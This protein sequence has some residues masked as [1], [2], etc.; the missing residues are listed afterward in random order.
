MVVVLVVPP[1]LFLSPL[2]V[3]RAFLDGDNFLQNFPLRVL[4]GEDIRQGSLPLLNPYLFSGTPLLGGFNAGAAYPATW[5][6]A[7]LPRFVAWSL[8][9]AVAYDV[10][11][12]GTFAYLRRQSLGVTPATFAAATFAFAGYMSGQIVHVDLIQ[13]AAWLPWAL[14]AVDALLPAAP[15]DVRAPVDRAR[16]ARWAAVLALVVGLTVLTGGAEVIIDGLLAVALY[17]LWQLV[18]QW[19]RGIGSRAVVVSAAW[20]L[21]G[22]AGGI[23]LGSAQWLPGLVFQSRSQRAIG[24]YT[25]FTT[26]SLDYHL[27][28]LLVSPFVLGTNQGRPTLF[29]G[30]YNLPEATGYAGVL[31]LIAVAVLWSRRFRRRPE[32]RA[33]RVW[34]GLGAVFLLS[35]LGG[36]TPFGHV[37]YLLPL[38]RDERLLNRNLLVVDFA[39]AVLLGWWLQ[40]L[41]DRRAD[42]E[43]APARPR[44]GSTRWTERIGWAPGR[45]CEILLTVTPAAL[46]VVAA[47][48]WWADGPLVLRLLDA[49][50]VIPASSRRELAALVTLGALIGVAGTAL[51]LIER[52]L[53]LVA[54]R[55]GLATVLA[56]DLVVLTVFLLHT[57][58][59]E[60]TAQAQTPQAAALARQAAGGRFLVYD[61]DQFFRDDLYAVGQTDLNVFAGTASGQGYTALT[62][63]HYYAATGAHFQEDLDPASLRGPLWDGL[64]ARVLLSLPGYFVTPSGP[65]PAGGSSVP[66]PP[67]PSPTAR[68]FTGAP[69]PADAPVT[70]APGRSHVWYLGGTLSVSQWSVPVET[71]SPDA[72]RAGVIAADGT[73]VAAPSTAVGHALEASASGAPLAGVVVRNGSP[74]TVVVGVPTARTAQAG[75]VALEG[76]MQYGVDASHWRF[77]G[78]LGPFGLFANTRAR[79]WAWAAA[80]PGGTSARATVAAG[81]PAVDGSQDVR[82]RSAGR[83][84]LVRSMAWTTGWR[85]T[86]DPVPGGPGAGG[87]SRLLQVRRDGVLQRVTVPPGDWT[88][89]FSYQPASATLGL[90][91]SLLA[92]VA[93]AGFL[94]V[95]GAARLRSGRRRD[96]DGDRGPIPGEPGAQPGGSS[97]MA[98]AARL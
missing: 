45:R 62:D 3:G 59:P 27:L 33:W 43:P 94:A 17:A 23:A 22:L 55:R 28:S 20:G 35:A 19:R 97:P 87:P 47:V 14:L 61:P 60:A 89:H 56:L 68:D 2:V 64:D 57:P 96:E 48:S 82:V 92:L 9:L 21:V 44:E 93:I 80:P 72:L 54:L 63:G 6:V 51:V 95:D 91:V 84:D 41:F 79:G 67:D 25:F 24:S 29:V 13:A 88:V 86:A 30:P 58:I 81:P 18:A 70:L 10:A 65:P 32:A 39:L 75:E 50:T 40:A 11:A 26:G 98:P 83:V 7:V 90:V 37:L 52:R 73:Q 46:M 15:A 38:I 42:A 71:G 66:F 53:S 31:A 12:L 85:A 4:T 1:L 36:E 77:V 69:L 5:L 78:T 34:Y 16:S 8:N 74:T 76:R 49:Q